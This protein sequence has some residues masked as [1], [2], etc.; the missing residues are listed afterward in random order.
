MTVQLASGL[1]DYLINDCAAHC[2]YDYYVLAQ[3]NP[4][5]NNYL[6]TNSTWS[7]NRQVKSGSS[8]KGVD[9][10]NNFLHGNWSLGPS[11][12]CDTNF[13]GAAAMSEAETHYQERIKAQVPNIALSVTLT[14]V[15]S[16]ISSS[17]AY[18]TGTPSTGDTGYLN[19]FVAAATGGGYGS[20]TYGSQHAKKYGHPLDYNTHKYNHSFNVAIEN[21]TASGGNVYQ[22]KNDQ[23]A[24]IIVKFIQGLMGL[25]SHAKVDQ[26]LPL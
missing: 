23:V 18:K 12:P 25:I 13:R 1:I 19:A 26:S 9:L 3:A 8:C 22:Y 15:G 17:L 7:K 16:K 6:S 24:P 20:G 2:S 4:D 14:E 21:G 11:D 10:L 5:G